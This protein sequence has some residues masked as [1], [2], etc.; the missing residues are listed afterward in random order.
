MERGI[1]MI[2][3]MIINAGIL[4]LMVI[5][6]FNCSDEKHYSKKNRM[7]YSN[8]KDT[9]THVRYLGQDYSKNE[10]NKLKRIEL[11][12]FKD[13]L[14]KQYKIP[15]KFRHT[16]YFNIAYRCSEYKM[17]RLQNYLLAFFKD[18][19][20]RF[21]KYE[22]LHVVKI[23]YFKN[24]ATFKRYSGSLAYGYFYPHLRT[25]TTHAYSGYGTLW[26]ELI[27]AFV[28]E[29][30]GSNVQEW[31]NEGFAS[32]YE[33]A[34]LRNNKV[35]DGFTNWR[36]PSL[37]RSIRRKDYSPLKEIMVEQRFYQYFG[38]AQA[39]FLFCYLRMYDVM[40]PFVK[41]Y[42]YDLL[43]NY[44]GKKLGQMAIK[45]IE[46]LIGKNIDSIDKEFKMLAM[47]YQKYKKLH[48]KRRYAAQR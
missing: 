48:K 22:P 26:H 23:I 25:I 3:K 37:Q 38:Y 35:I 8:V 44:S 39:R 1:I 36:M 2:K 34:L 20:P 27:H 4:L 21:F 5:F 30:G 11:R 19:Y 45:K 28:H 10:Y 13:Q 41:S 24:W 33:M 15:F 29:N 42:M 46:S 47:R 14:K 32:F 7:L 40:D 31:F 9:R 6:S 12:E 18:I 16:K 17:N 43:P